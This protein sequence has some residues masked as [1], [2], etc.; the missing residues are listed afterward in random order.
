MGTSWGLDKEYDLIGKI[1]E[2]TY[3][4]VYLATSKQDKRQLYAIKKFK[5]G[6][7]GDGIS[8]TA[9]REI[10]LLRELRHEHIV[11]L[12]AV[13]V[14]RAEPSL[15]L[16]FDY[17]EHDLY[18]IIWHHRDRLAGPIDTYVVKSLMWQLL[19]GLSYLH[20]NWIIHRDLKAPLRPL[21]DNGV[22]VTIWYRPPELLLG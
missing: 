9:I 11:K 10:L 19:N 3:G 12:T 15:S 1:G 22:V 17:A 16:A 4:V 6:R 21:A 13:H 20:Q 2:G 5:T 7:E 8:P 18:E 14:N